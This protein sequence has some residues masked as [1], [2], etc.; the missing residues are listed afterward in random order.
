MLPSEAEREKAARGVDGRAHPWG[1][2][3]DVGFANLG[4]SAADPVGMHPEDKSA[5]GYGIQHA[6]ASDYSTVA[7]A[8]N[9]GVPLTLT[10]HSELATQFSR[11]TRAVLN[12]PAEGD[13]VE[14]RRGIFLGLF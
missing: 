1:D 14:G 9:A 10:N 5:L 6:F 4:T 13:A 3:F 11:F 12:L 2:A 8:L 7:A